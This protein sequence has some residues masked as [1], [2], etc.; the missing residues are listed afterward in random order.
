[1]IQSTRPWRCRQ[2]AIDRP[3]A[4]AFGL[5]F[6]VSGTQLFTAVIAETHGIAGVGIALTRAIAVS[7]PPDFGRRHHGDQCRPELHRRDAGGLAV[8][9]FYGGDLPL[10][11]VRDDRGAAGGDSVGRGLVWRPVARTQRPDPGSEACV[12]AA[13]AA[14]RGPGRG[15]WR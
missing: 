1:M 11:P 12:L 7:P 2:A 3:V 10:H 8:G 13:N 5:L 6:L 14:A 15:M 9:G 4:A